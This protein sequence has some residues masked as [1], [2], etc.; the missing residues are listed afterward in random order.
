VFYKFIFEKMKKSTLLVYS[1]IFT[2]IITGITYAGGK[3]GRKNLE[4][5]RTVLNIEH[6]DHISINP[7]VPFLSSLA[8]SFEGAA[9][10]PTGWIQYRAA[11]STDPGWTRLTL[12]APLPG[13]NGG[14]ITTPPG[15]GNAV[16]FVTFN[17]SVN[18]NDEWLVTP[19]LNNIQTN[20]S[21]YFWLQKPGY[22]RLYP[23]N[24]DIKIST[25]TNA[26]SSFTIT[27]ANL[28][29]PANGSDTNWTRRSYSIGNLVTPGANIYIAWREHVTDNNSDGA[30]FS[31]DL[32]SITGLPLG[33]NNINGE[34]P[35]SFSLE[36]NY[37][38]PFNPTTNIK[39]GLPSSGQ[40]KLAVYDIL[41]NEV[42]VLIDGY[43]IAGNYVTDFNASNLASGIYF[44]KLV[45]KDFISTKRMIL[46][47]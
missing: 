13:W 43:K 47:K 10:P 11:G 23:D 19:L 9:F 5:K 26:I 31:L 18:S 20:D 39:F 29:F 27:V 46:I 17:T 6:L 12:G 21:L 44:Y 28:V 1:L 22:T 3:D 41:G 8:E 15:G 4:S 37:P 24:I 33:I 35:K 25:T 45:S 34:V 30:A 36:Q 7:P 40:V 42:A 38:N 14:F 2:F 16:A 32:V